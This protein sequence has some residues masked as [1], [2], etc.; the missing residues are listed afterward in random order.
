MPESEEKRETLQNTAEDTQKKRSKE[1]LP[2]EKFSGEKLLRFWREKLTLRKKLL[3]AAAL[4]LVPGC[5]FAKGSG[6]K[7][8]TAQAVRKAVEDTASE[9]GVISSGEEKAILSE[10]SGPVAGILVSENDRVKEGQVLYRIDP[11]LYDFEKQ[12]AESAV[13]ALEAQMDRAKIGQVMT[14][15]PAEYLDGLGKELAAAESAMQAAKSTWEGMQV[16]AAGGDAARLELE[17]AEAQYRSAESTYRQ[18]QERYQE[19]RTLMEKLEKEGITGD[20]LNDTF[21]ESENGMLEAE[22]EG[23]RTRLRQLEDRIERCEVK[24]GEDGIITSLP[25]KQVSAVQEGMETVCIRPAEACLA[26]ADVLTSVVP[27]LSVNGPCEI[28]VSRKGQD[29]KIPGH[30]TEIYDFASAGTSALGL[31]EYRV[32]VKIAPENP[33]DLAGKEGYGV[34]VRFLLYEGEDVLTVPADAVFEEDG[35]QYVYL[36]QGR[37]AVKTEISSEYQTGTDAVI[38]GGLSENDRVIARADAEDIHD[39]VR[40]R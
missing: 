22:L 30:V 39:G 3:L 38:T 8:E 26:E 31:S 21:F 32:H 18:A 6:I 33:E 19:S 1:K 15:S 9:E 17:Q 27:W 40:V 28:T 14:T 11:V 36:V 23:S 25:I 34:T 20:K 29:E 12:A 4:V 37:R 16:L 24:A 7:A 35:K 10:V 5:L 13:R 2:A